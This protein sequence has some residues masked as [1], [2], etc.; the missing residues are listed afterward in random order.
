MI[1]ENSSIQ[2]LS[3]YKFLEKK[4]VK[5][6]LNINLNIQDDGNKSQKNS[7]LTDT[8]EIS[9][10][11]DDEIGLTP[12]LKMVKMLL[13]RMINRKIILTKLETD[14]P[15]DIK[16]ESQEPKSD[17]QS[18]QLSVEYNRSEIHYESEETNFSA[19]GIIQTADGKKIN[20]DMKL[21]LGREFVSENNIDF[22]IGKPKDPL[23]INFNGASTQLT[24]MKF[25]FDIDSDGEKDQIS[26]VNSNSGFLAIDKNGDNKINNGSEL[27]GPTTGNGFTELK[28]YDSDNNNWID[29]NDSIYNNLLIWTKD[30]QGKDVLAKLKE[31]GI[32]A[33]YLDY[34]KTP[35]NLN[36]KQNIIQGV[37]KSSGVYANENGS[38]GTIQQI[39]LMV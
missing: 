32:G 24:D 16:F 12:E 9:N 19:K 4:S 6:S 25:A 20:F 29:E 33:I 21:S 3:Q 37:L 10:Q 7:L 17:S 30:N 8:I 1:I 2:F 14:S 35:F 11:E 38:V 31:K 13:E 34:D 28:N 36:D 5:E 18:N 27:F 26:F 23:I 15:D 39:D 22:G